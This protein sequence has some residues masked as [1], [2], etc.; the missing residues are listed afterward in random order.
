MSVA[1]EPSSSM[2]SEAQKQA[3]GLMRREQRKE[4]AVIVEQNERTPADERVKGAND[5][6][7]GD[8]DEEIILS[9]V[10]PSSHFLYQHHYHGAGVSHGDVSPSNQYRPSR[11]RDVHHQRPEV[12]DRHHH[13]PLNQMQESF[14]P[15]SDEEKLYSHAMTGS[16]NH[17][18]TRDEV[19]ASS[20]PES[21]R[22][23]P[24]I[25]L[26]DFPSSSK[27]YSGHHFTQQSQLHKEQH[28]KA[29]NVSQSRIIPRVSDTASES[30]GHDSRHSREKSRSRDQEIEDCRREMDGRRISLSNVHPSTS[31]SN[32]SRYFVVKSDI[33]GRPLEPSTI[34]ISSSKHH[35]HQHQSLLTQHRMS[36]YQYELQEEHRRKLM[37]H[38]F[39]QSQARVL[40]LQ[41]EDSFPSSSPAASCA[42]LPQTLTSSSAMVKGRQITTRA[43]NM[44]QTTRAH[45]PQ[46]LPLAGSQVR[47]F[48]ERETPS[49]GRSLET[50]HRSSS[51]S[52]P[53]TLGGSRCSDVQLFD[54]RSSTDALSRHHH[55]HFGQQRPKFQS[56][57][58]L[59]SGYP[60]SYVSTHSSS[61]HDLPQHKDIS[62]YTE[63]EALFATHPTSSHSFPCFP[64]EAEQE[65]YHFNRM[66]DISKP[67]TYRQRQRFHEDFIEESDF[68]S[69]ISAQKPF[70][71]AKENVRQIVQRPSRSATHVPP[72]NPYPS[73]R[74]GTIPHQVL[75]FNK[76]R[77]GAS[78]KM[79][80]PRPFPRSSS[81]SALH[82]GGSP[83]ASSVPAMVAGGLSSSSSQVIRIRPILRPIPSVGM[84]TDE[85][86]DN[87]NATTQITQLHTIES[88]NGR[89]KSS[90]EG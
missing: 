22:A 65:F 2:S 37:Q 88:P 38:S 73:T 24:D 34:G 28:N 43:S 12:H 8:R 75:E 20:A 30:G 54:V 57:Q 6:N 13:Q 68:T 11:Q 31:Q 52:H 80:T 14:V 67:N 69:P 60:Q 87:N 49:R 7:R 85:I 10:S 32:Q 4:R 83:S 44:N 1:L 48:S 79:S 16:G 50:V 33:H 26:Q 62:R 19:V 86:S 59:H 17:S 74:Y 39:H 29:S 53:V 71:G 45:R 9:E 90:E 77:P 89:D 21:T 82:G 3:T 63:N 51:S 56:I 36:R 46:Q 84:T 58:R 61:P 55:R 5:P 35:H 41:R 23:T 27:D 18:P 47:T 76:M 64:S 25:L 81:S 72:M 40:A 42:S 70:D 66:S 78:S 15:V